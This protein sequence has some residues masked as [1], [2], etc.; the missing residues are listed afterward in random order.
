MSLAIWEISVPSLLAY[1]AGAS[2][3]AFELIGENEILWR[4]GDEHLEGIMFDLR[5]NR[6][7][8]HKADLGVI[9]GWAEHKGPAFSC[10]ARGGVGIDFGFCAR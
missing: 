3:Q 10:P 1:H 7:A 4:S 5:P 6:I 8:D 9:C 2:V